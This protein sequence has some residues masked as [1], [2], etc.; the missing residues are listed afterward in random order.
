MPNEVSHAH[1]AWMYADPS[2]VVET[3][4]LSDMGCRACSKHLMFNG[5][6]ACTEPKKTHQKDVPHIGKNCKF[7]ELKG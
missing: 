6:V 5:R 7:F 1:P 3:Q 4:Q 2:K